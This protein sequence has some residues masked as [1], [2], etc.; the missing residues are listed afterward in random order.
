MTPQVKEA[1]DRIAAAI[2]GRPANGYSDA[3]LAAD[4]VLV[5]DS[6]PDGKRSKIANNLRF[7]ANNAREYRQDGSEKEIKVHQLAGQLAELVELAG[8]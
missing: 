6:I 3:I 8:A 7:G 5:A 1:V 4:V 2:Q